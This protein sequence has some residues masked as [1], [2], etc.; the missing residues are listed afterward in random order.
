M[1]RFGQA[2][3][4]LTSVPE[5]GFEE[6]H[7][8]A[9]IFCA[10]RATEVNASCQAWESPSPRS[11]LSTL[12]DARLKPVKAGGEDIPFFPISKFPTACYGSLPC[13]AFTTLIA[14]SDGGVVRFA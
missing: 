3:G 10:T 13:F 7:K 6:V 1:M 14:T 4:D 9:V 2:T 12:V 5:G 8:Q 11:L